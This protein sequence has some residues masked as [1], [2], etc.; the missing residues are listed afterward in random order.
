MKKT[1][2]LINAF[3]LFFLCSITNVAAQGPHFIHTGDDEPIEETTYT[4][5]DFVYKM[6]KHKIQEIKI[7]LLHKIG[8]P[9]SNDTNQMVWDDSNGGELMKNISVVLKNRKLIIKSNF[10]DKKTTANFNEIK[11]EIISLL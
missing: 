2:F 7:Y 11:R 8:V 10:A 3:L 6:N 1:A 5:L 4:K 9:I